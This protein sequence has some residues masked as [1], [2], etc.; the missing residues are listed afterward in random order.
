LRV[1]KYIT[2]NSHVEEYGFIEPTGMAE[3]PFG[4]TDIGDGLGYVVFEGYWAAD[5]FAKVPYSSV[6]GVEF[7]TVHVFSRMRRVGLSLECGEFM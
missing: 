3:V 5:A 7:A 1:E 6:I 2:G 4:W